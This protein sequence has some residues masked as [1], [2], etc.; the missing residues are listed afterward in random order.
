MSAGCILQ[1]NQR[2]LFKLLTTTKAAYMVPLLHLG[3]PSS[4][5]FGVKLSKFLVLLFR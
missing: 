1:P 4:S 3:I 5:I 2:G